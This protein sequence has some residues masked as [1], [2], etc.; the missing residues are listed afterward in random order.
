MDQLL[1]IWIMKKI[2]SPWYGI[3]WILIWTAALLW[4]LTSGRFDQRE[5][6]GLFIVWVAMVGITVYYIALHVIRIGKQPRK[7]IIKQAAKPDTPAR[8]APCP[9]GSG[10]KYKR[11]CAPDAP[12]STH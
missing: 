4:F 10:K 9:C 8:N 1:N 5:S 6:V 11:C 2:K 7:P 12:A 3:V